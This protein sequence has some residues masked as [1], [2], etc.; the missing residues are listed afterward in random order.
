M[1]IVLDTSILIEL[2]RGNKQVFDRL[3]SLRKVYPAPARISFISYF[4]FL[5]GLRDKSVKNKDKYSIFLNKFGVIYTNKNTAQV[6]VD[7]KKSYELPLSDLLIAAQ[8]IDSR[9]ILVTKDKDF[10]IIKELNKIII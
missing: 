7:L 8:V 5:Y 4:E 10:E 6:L 2:E 1:N 3:D 9:A